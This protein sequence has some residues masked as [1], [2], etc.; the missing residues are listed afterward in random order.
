MHVAHDRK[1]VDGCFEQG[2]GVLGSAKLG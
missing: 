2:C 1:G